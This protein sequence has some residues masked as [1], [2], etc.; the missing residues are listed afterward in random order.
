MVE[1]VRDLYEAE[2][3]FGDDAVSPP[4]PTRSTLAP[5][6]A[7]RSTA[8]GRLADMRLKAVDN[9]KDFVLLRGPLG[10]V[11]FSVGHTPI[12]KAIWRVWV[13]KRIARDPD[14]GASIADIVAATG[15]NVKTVRNVVASLKKNHVIRSRVRYS[16]WRGAQ[17]TYYPSDAGVQALALAEV[18]GPGHSVQVGR[19]A[20]AWTS[21][22]QTEP[23]TLFQHAAL[24]RGGAA[25]AAFDTEYP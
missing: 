9:L 14:P 18:L 21:R 13:Q 16:G 10:V 1:S 5:D 17:A 25:P 15:E 6:D 19:T 23:G 20:Q 2:E 12:L 7:A 11:R 22:S 3:A 24:L 4:R 8:G